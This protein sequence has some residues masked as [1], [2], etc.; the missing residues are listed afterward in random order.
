MT[1]AS[2]AQMNEN[3]CDVELGMFKPRIEVWRLCMFASLPCDSGPHK[4]ST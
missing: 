3:E 4:E 1:L 2:Q